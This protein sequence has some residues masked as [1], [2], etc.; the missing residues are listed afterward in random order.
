MKGNLCDKSVQGRNWKFMKHSYA[1]KNF[2]EPTESDYS[3]ARKRAQRTHSPK[4][5]ST[6]GP[7]K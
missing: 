1:W 2:Q 4:R 3:H 7:K 6:Q 5:N